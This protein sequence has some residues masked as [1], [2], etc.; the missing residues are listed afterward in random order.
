LAPPNSSA[1]SPDAAPQLVAAVEAQ[2]GTLNKFKGEFKMLLLGI[3]GSGWGWVVRNGNGPLELVTTK[4]QDPVTGDKQV[5]LGVDMWEHAYYL[6]YWSDKAS[7]VDGIWKVVNW[8]VAEKR[9]LGI[10]EPLTL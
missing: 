7:Y 9:F 1:A 3:Q 2:Y 10:E 8:E 4:D 5:V 6:Q